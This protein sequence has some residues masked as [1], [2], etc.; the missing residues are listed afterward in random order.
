METYYLEQLD[1]TEK[2]KITPCVLALGFFDGVHIGHRGILETARQAAK[3]TGYA[4]SVMTFYPHPKDILFPD[5]EPMTYLTP[6]PVKEERFRELGVDQLFIVKFTPEFARLSPEAF[7]GRYILAL[8]CKHVVAGFDYHYGHKGKG[9][10]GTLTEAGRGL[11]DVTTVQKITDQ[12]EKVSSTAIRERLAAGRVEEVP[13]LL[14][15]F[16]EVMGE[17]KQPSLFYRNYQFMK[18]DVQE[19]YRLPKPGVYVVKAEVDGR[20]YMGVCQQMSSTGRQSTLLIQLKDCL[21]DISGK[22]VKIKWIEHIY[23]RYR[24]TSDM[25]DYIQRDE[26][27]I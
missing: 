27:V 18:V 21:T 6:L 4:F 9:N 12:E 16:Y 5:R 15:D 17:V 2:I 1:D 20:L 23:S 7:I 25:Y 3:E 24:E 26:M 10:M 11:F 19:E 8:Q 22:E 14:G 13:R